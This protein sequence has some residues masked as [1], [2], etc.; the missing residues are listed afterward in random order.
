MRYN[1]VYHIRPHPATPKKKRKGSKMR[2]Y[3]LLFF[4]RRPSMSRRI[5]LRRFPDLPSGERKKSSRLHR[6]IAAAQRFDPHV[7]E[8]SGIGISAFRGF[9]ERRHRAADR[10]L[11]QNA[12]LAYLVFNDA[13]TGFRVLRQPAPKR[14]ARQGNSVVH[15]DTPP[16]E[17]FTDVLLR[18]V[19]AARRL[20]VFS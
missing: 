9:A 14:H 20:A 18:P 4:Q 15:S 8:H 17:R 5:L 16:V 11:R 6:L 19:R 7:A 1:T 12:V 3:A 2:K 10:D 13:Q